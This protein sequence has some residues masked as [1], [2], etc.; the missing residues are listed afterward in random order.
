[1][2]NIYRGA[3]GRRFSILLKVFDSSSYHAIIAVELNIC[4][5]FLSVT[6]LDMEEDNARPRSGRAFL[7]RHRLILPD[8]RAHLIFWPFMVVGLTLDLWTKS[9]VFNWLEIGESVS[10]VD[11]IVQLVRAENPGAA[12]SIAAGHP[13]LLMV[14]SIAALIVI[15]AIFLFNRTQQRLVHIALGLFAAGICGNL[16]DRIANSGLV[17]DFIDVVYWPNKHWPAFNVADALL[18]VGVGLLIISTFQAPKR[19]S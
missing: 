5:G 14:V 15:F 13:N 2:S 3:Q 6:E 1:M 16:Y 7:K 4:S 18:C 11:G 10:I 17:R 8:L 19:S 9:A 12:F